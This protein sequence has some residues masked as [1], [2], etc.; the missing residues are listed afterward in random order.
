MHSYFRALL[1][2][3]M[4]IGKPSST[5]TGSLGIGYNNTNE[6]ETVTSLL[7]YENVKVAPLR[8]SFKVSLIFYSAFYLFLSIK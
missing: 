6:P 8:V 5:T 1:F 2:A 3:S 7:R 4:T